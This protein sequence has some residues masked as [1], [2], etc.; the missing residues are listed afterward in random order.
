MTASIKQKCFDIVESHPDRCSLFTYGEKVEYFVE[1]SEILS[2]LRSARFGS[3]F[4]LRYLDDS[5]NDYAIRVLVD[6]R[7][8]IEIS[9][10][11]SAFLYN[12]TKQ[13]S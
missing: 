3:H 5:D 7:R 10:F 2:Y 8:W 11:M 9:D 1:E 6:E 12:L 4:C 13:K